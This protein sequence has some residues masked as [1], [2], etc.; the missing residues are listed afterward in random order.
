MDEPIGNDE[1]KGLHALPEGVENPLN[2]NSKSCTRLEILIDVDLDELEGC[3][4]LGFWFNYEE[5]LQLYVILY[6]P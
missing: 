2:Q 6:L 3:W 5:I 1:M 4:D